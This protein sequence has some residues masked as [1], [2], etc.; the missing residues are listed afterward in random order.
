VQE[1]FERLVE[2][3]SRITFER[4]AA[5]VGTVAEVLVEGAG[6]KGGSTQARTRTNRIVHLV[7]PLDAGTFVDA[8]ITEAAPHHLLGEAV[9]APAEV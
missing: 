2:L 4:N 7:E 5:Q 3:Q 6:K 8:R 1:R 9:R